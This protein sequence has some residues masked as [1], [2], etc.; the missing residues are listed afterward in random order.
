MMAPDATIYPTT[1]HVPDRELVFKPKSS[2]VVPRSLTLVAVKVDGDERLDLKDRFGVEG[3]PT[4]VLLGS[5]GAE[6]RRESGY[7]NVAN[8]TRFL[9]LSR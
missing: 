2:G 5:D 4:M 3:F 7:V 1:G 9:D 8:M 6:L